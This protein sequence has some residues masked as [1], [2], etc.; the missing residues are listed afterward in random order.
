MERKISETFE[1]EGKTFK[2]KESEN[3]GCHGCFFNKRCT[4]PVIKMVGECAA[5]CREDNK[6]VVFVEVQGQTQKTKEPKERKIGETFEFEGH[7][8]KVVDKDSYGCDGC[9]F[10]NRECSSIKDVRGFCSKEYRTDNKHVIFVEA[11]DEQPRELNLCEI[12]K[13]CPIGT[14][15]YS[16]A[17]GE[18]TYFLGITSCQDDVKPI[19]IRVAHEKGEIYCLSSRGHLYDDNYGE[20]CIFPSKEM[21]D[22]SKFTAPWLKKERFDPKTLS[23]FDRVLARNHGSHKWTCDLFSD[24]ID[25]NEC[26]YHCIGSYYRYCI[27]Y[28]DDT[29]HL[30]DTKEDAPVFYRYWED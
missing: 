4:L 15:L 6:G 25:G 30:V 23:P 8:L 1:F 28:N 14:K 16:P 2:V 17:F 27:P 29:K 20:C 24:I 10:L 12:L 11:K 22:W 26:M 13:D 7:K 3:C 9:F 18:E 19:I 5:A 21:R